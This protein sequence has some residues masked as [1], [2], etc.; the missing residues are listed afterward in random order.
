[1][2][3][4]WCDISTLG[5][6]ACLSRNCRE[7]K[8]GDGILRALLSSYHG[9]EE[10]VPQA[11]GTSWELYTGG[12]DPLVRCVADALREALPGRKTRAW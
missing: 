11:S 1:M 10:E 3:A 12:G 7:Y 5:V 8:I 2:V 9:T 4:E 6:I